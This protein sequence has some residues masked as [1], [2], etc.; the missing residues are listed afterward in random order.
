VLFYLGTHEAHWLRLTDV[1]LFVSRRR[2]VK[3]KT[4]PRALGRWALDS[5]GFTEISQFGGWEVSPSQYISEVRRFKDEIGNMDW[6][7]PQDWMCE[8]MMLE[9]TGLAV[10]DHQRLTIESYLTL[11]TEA[12][13]L[14]FIPV[15]Q[16]WE[17]GD[18]LDHIADYERAGINLA[19]EAVVGLGSV[20]RRQNTTEAAHIVRA[21]S[22]NGINLHGFGFKVAG[23]RAAGDA[24]TSADSLAWSYGARR[25]PPLRGCTHQSCSNCI[26]YALQW[27]EKVMTAI[28]APKQPALPGDWYR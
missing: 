13:D 2:L 16:G 21:L 3:R 24:M 7:A 12:P 10:K 4:L 8:P 17:L 22:G 9:R 27:R 1:P 23:L 5:G 28:D 20:C 15:L 19:D 6:A 25:Q 26:K 14:P 11:R 18:Y